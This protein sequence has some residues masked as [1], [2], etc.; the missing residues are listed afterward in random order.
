MKAWMKLIRTMTL[1]G[2]LG[3]TLITP[4]VVMALLGWWLQ[5]RFGLGVW[6][7]LI[8]LVIGLLTAAASA[9]RFYRRVMAQMQK[10]AEAEEPAEKPVVFYTHE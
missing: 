1:L 8:C 2:Q 9:L 10:R 5:S 3:F 6:V 4:P 7:M